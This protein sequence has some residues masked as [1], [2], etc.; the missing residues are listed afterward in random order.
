MVVCTEY[1]GVTCACSRCV[2]VMSF[3]VLIVSSCCVALEICWH[4]YKRRPTLRPLFTR[5]FILHT[6]LVQAVAPFSSHAFTFITHNHD[7]WKSF[8]WPKWQRPALIPISWVTPQKPHICNSLTAVLTTIITYTIRAKREKMASGSLHNNALKF[9]ASVHSDCVYFSFR[10]NLKFIPD[11]SIIGNTYAISG[12]WTTNILFS[13]V[14]LLLVQFIHV[15]IVRRVC[16]ELILC[17]R[18]QHFL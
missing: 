5:L 13:Q 10:D 12:S 18:R 4:L 16:K 7:L 14:L 6:K 2:K 3:L 9:N 8:T 17:S 15:N 1:C 11:S